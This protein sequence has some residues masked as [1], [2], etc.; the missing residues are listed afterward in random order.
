VAARVQREHEWAPPP[1]L[2][3]VD[4]PLRSQR[5]RPRPGGERTQQ[6]APDHPR[7]SA[8]SRSLRDAASL[9]E[10][11]LV[12]MVAGNHHVAMAYFSSV[13][14]SLFGADDL[15]AHRAPRKVVRLPHTEKTTRRSVA[16]PD[17]G[18]TGV[19]A[20]ASR[21]YRFRQVLIGKMSMITM[22]TIPIRARGGRGGPRGAMSRCDVA[23][24]NRTRTQRT[25]EQRLVVDPADGSRVLRGASN[26]TANS[27]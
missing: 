8:R 3:E 15:A 19:K 7:R 12:A 22:P 10:S 6:P 27:V 18:V 1:V 11:H 24:R 16:P 25:V 20:V 5:P 9:R 23:V 14:D 2:P 17:R 4:G 26:A 13:V 21:D